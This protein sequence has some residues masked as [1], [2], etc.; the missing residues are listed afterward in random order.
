VTASAPW[1]LL[2]RL[3][4]WREA[5]TLRRWDDAGKSEELSARSFADFPPLMGGLLI[6][7]GT[8]ARLGGS[9]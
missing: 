3:P 8:P 2:E 5:V 9:V 7:G 6:G 4:Y 1:P